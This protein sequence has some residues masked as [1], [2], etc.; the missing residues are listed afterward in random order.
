MT[1]E[2]QGLYQYSNALM[3]RHCYSTA[4]GAMEEIQT[5][6]QDC[7]AVQSSNGTTMDRVQYNLRLMH[8]KQISRISNNTT[9][10]DCNCWMF[11]E[12]DNIPGR[13]DSVR[14]LYIQSQKWQI[15]HLIGLS[16]ANTV[17]TLA[18]GR[19]SR[20]FILSGVATERNKLV[21]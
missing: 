13:P 3:R 4:E 21:L 5:M 8:L 19:L 9:W 7:E 10:A 16:T 14:H 20:R 2:I 15:L 18:L 12:C 17:G 1:A 6:L 11:I